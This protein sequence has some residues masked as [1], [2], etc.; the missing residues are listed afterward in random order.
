MAVKGFVRAVE[1]WLRLIMFSN[2]L[3]ARKSLRTM[4][5]QVNAA[6]KW[7]QIVLLA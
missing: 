1:E 7:T 3:C 2:V 4:K 6:L 5:L